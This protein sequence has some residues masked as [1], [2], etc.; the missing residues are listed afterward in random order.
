MH[1]IFRNTA[2]GMTSTIKKYVN[3]ENTIKADRGFQLVAAYRQFLNLVEDVNYRPQRSCSKVM[4]LHMSVILSTGGPVWQTH[5]LADT[6]SPDT[7]WADIPLGQTAPQSPW[8]TPPSDGHCSRRYASYWN[9]F[10]Y[11]EYFWSLLNDWFYRHKKSAIKKQVMSRY[12]G[13]LECMLIW[14]SR[15][16]EACTYLSDPSLNT[17]V[18]LD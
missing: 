3:A 17:M 15:L 7:P 4:F 5:P 1:V 12:D 11:F 16:T 13:M 14:V 9:A 6:P 10:L 18:I 2:T 8:Q